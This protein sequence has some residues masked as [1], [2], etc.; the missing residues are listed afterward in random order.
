MWTEYKDSSQFL[1]YI[2]DH[3]IFSSPVFSG[4]GWVHRIVSTCRFLEGVHVAKV[5]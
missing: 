2:V 1:T 4:N 3:S 5:M